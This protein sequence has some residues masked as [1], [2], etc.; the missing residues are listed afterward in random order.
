MGAF[1]GL[2]HGVDADEAIADFALAATSP[3]Y[4]EPLG[5]N[6]RQYTATG[7][8]SKKKRARSKW[9]IDMSRI[10]G[11]SIRSRKSVRSG[12]EKWAPM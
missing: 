1:R 2:P 5:L 12:G 7:S 11:D 3:L 9:W 6:S 10:S 4:H 8:A